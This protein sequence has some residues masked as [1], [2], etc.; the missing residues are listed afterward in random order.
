MLR[1]VLIMQHRRMQQ[2]LVVEP[3][4][5]NGVMRSWA[6]YNWYLVEYHYV[7]PADMPGREILEAI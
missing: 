7:V 6:K 5:V 3:S 1:V 4:Q 2:T